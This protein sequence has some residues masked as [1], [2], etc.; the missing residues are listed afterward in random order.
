MSR[1]LQ[2][3]CRS[4]QSLV[5]LGRPAAPSKEPSGVSVPT[6]DRFISP[7]LR[8]LAEHLDGVRTAESSSTERSYRC[9]FGTA[10][11][12]EQPLNRAVLVVFSDVVDVL[13]HRAR[14]PAE[15]LRDRSPPEPP[16]EQ[17]Q[18]SLVRLGKRA[19]R[20]ARARR[21]GARKGRRGSAARP[22][23]AIAETRRRRRARYAR[24]RARSPPAPLRGSADRARR[25]SC[26]GWPRARSGVSSDRSRRSRRPG[27]RR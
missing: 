17:D 4:T 9:S 25:A 6:Y 10:R 13:L 8:Y 1:E 27:S 24:G 23:A 11:A 15:A 2:A 14:R 19:R 3:I 5:Q 16:P 21:W 7:L 12:L 22:P 18:V 20:S 26:L